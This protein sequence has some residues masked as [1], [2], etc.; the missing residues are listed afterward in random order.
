MAVFRVDK[1]LADMGVGTRSGIKEDIRRGRVTVNDAVIRRADW[2]I[3]TSKDRV[4]FDGVPVSYVEYEYFMLNKPAGVVSATQDTRDQTVL[5]LITEKNRRDLFPVGR[6]DKD[7]EGLLLI[8]NDGELAHT[9][10]LPKKHVDKVYFAKIDGVVTKDHVE[11]FRVGLAVDD[12]FSAMPAEL[13]ILRTD[14]EKGT[15]EV[16]LT[17]REGKFHQ[18][19]RMFEACGMRVT[20][21]KRLRM[22]NLELDPGLEPG[23]Y[24]ELTAEEIRLLR[25]VL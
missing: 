7:T 19:K 8:T 9:L 12:D 22:G 20:Y 1:Y 6:L 2:K 14:G 5:D 4:C 13:V 24:R 15:S 17:I 16:E 10:L 25:G 18:V 11:R 21:L 23:Q 3:D